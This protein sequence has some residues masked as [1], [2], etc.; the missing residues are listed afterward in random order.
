MNRH[1]GAVF[2]QSLFILLLFFSFNPCAS[3]TQTSVE[4]SGLLDT[5]E[6]VSNSENSGEVPRGASSADE[7]AYSHTADG[8]D[9]G[10]DPSG[11][12]GT[13]ILGN[14]DFEAQGS[15]DS[16]G[17]HEDIHHWNHHDHDGVAPVPVP[18]AVWLLAS[19]IAGLALTSRWKVS[20]ANVAAL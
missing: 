17:Y 16:H 19:G 12:I 13:H 10:F 18:P 7:H 1:S 8:S 3:A 14:D 11:G 9:I 15:H 2:S 5:E 6:A 4:I 20:G